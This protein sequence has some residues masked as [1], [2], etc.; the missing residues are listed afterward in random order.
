MNEKSLTIVK[1]I[2]ATP[3]SDNSQW[4][5]RFQIKSASSG[6]HYIV[7]QRKSDGT[8]GC[9]CMGWKRYRTCRHLNTL[10]PT[11]NQIK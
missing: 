11:L 5:N 10:S 7:A 6:R 2:G 9:S 1:N 3:L 8:W 4:Q